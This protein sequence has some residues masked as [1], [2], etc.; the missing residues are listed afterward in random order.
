MPGRARPSG[1]ARVVGSAAE[2]HALGEDAGPVAEQLPR[3]ADEGLVDVDHQ[4]RR[5]VRRE[6]GRAAGDPGTRRR[7]QPILRSL[8]EFDVIGFQSDHDRENFAACL[9]RL[10]PEAAMESG[11]VIRRSVSPEGVR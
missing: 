11:P 5:R 9:E 7:A 6:V 1:P 3:Q 4:R 2:R 8:L 10:L